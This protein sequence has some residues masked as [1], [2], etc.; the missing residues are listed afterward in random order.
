MRASVRVAGSEV[1]DGEPRAVA[2]ALRIRVDELE[3]RDRD[4]SA[5]VGRFG[6]ETDALRNQARMVEVQNNELRHALGIANDKVR[7]APCARARVRKHL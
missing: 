7:G 4:F 3:A 1:S 5:Q 6:L 2:A